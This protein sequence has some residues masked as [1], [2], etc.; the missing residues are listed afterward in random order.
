MKT[1]YFIIWSKV[2]TPWPLLVLH[3]ILKKEFELRQV[4]FGQKMIVRDKLSSWDK[5]FDF[6]RPNSSSQL[7]L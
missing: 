2:G 6:F 4:V 7:P 1:F 5:S 3:L